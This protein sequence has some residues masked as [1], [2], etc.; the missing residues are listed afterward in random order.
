MIPGNEGRLIVALADVAENC[1]KLASNLRNTGDADWAVGAAEQYAEKIAEEARAVLRELVASPES[2]SPGEERCGGSGKLWRPVDATADNDDGDWIPCPGCPDCQSHECEV[3]DCT[4][5]AHK[6]DPDCQP[7]PSQDDYEA[8]V[9]PVHGIIEETDMVEGQDPALA[10]AADPDGWTDTFYCGSCPPDNRKPTRLER[11]C[12]VSQRDEARREVESWKLAN[13]ILIDGIGLTRAEVDEARRE[14]DEARAAALLYGP[15]LG[16]LHTA[17]QRIAELEG[18]IGGEICTSTP[19]PSSSPAEVWGEIVGYCPECREEFYAPEGGK[20][21][22]KHVGDAPDLIEYC[23]VSQRDEARRERDDWEAAWKRDVPKARGELAAAVTRAEAA[24]RERD[25]AVE[26]ID[27][28]AKQI[29]WEPGHVSDARIGDEHRPVDYALTLLLSAEQR[30]AELEGALKRIARETNKSGR[31]KGSNT[32]GY[33]T[34]RQL[35]RSALS[36]NPASED[37]NE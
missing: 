8:W 30:I 22:A 12:P 36:P 29:G 11:L 35:A 5:P 14:R 28:L 10:T 9:C 26:Q 16:H 24:R 15:T 31:T 37:T 6:V 27:Y 2:G 7:T 33:G 23:P 4:D 17:E 3:I 1:E 34:I 32:S 13:A 18:L 20:C 19:T 21:P 25:E